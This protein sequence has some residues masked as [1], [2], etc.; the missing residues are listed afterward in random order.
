MRY[1]DFDDLLKNKAALL[2][3]PA[4]LRYGAKS[5]TYKELYEAV[6]AKAEEYKASGRTCLGVLADGSADCV[7][8]LFGAAKAGLQL[9]M[10]DANLPDAAYPLLLAYTD[11]DILWGDPDLCE[12]LEPHLAGGVKDGAGK[13]LFFTS[14]T[15][16]RSK[17][18][19]LTQYSLCQSAWN[20]GSLLP[21]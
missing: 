14:G 3:D 8:S 21:L 2:P 12:E 6:C 7:I 4:A 5:W 1:H 20:G 16:S 11:V 17:A 18:V 9:V 13:V 10:L 15:T 19:E